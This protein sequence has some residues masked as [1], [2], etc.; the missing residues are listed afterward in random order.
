MQ[1]TDVREYV[2]RAGWGC[3]D[4]RETESSL[5]EPAAFGR[6]MQEARRRKSGVA[7]GWKLVR[8]SRGSD[9]CIKSLSSAAGFRI[10][11]KTLGEPGNAVY[12]GTGF[13][14]RRAFGP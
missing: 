8:L 5:S 10:A 4:Y 6:R 13:V 2:R 3:V 11:N 1:L 7:H 14:T 9:R 12:K